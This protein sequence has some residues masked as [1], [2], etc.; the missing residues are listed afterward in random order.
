MTSKIRCIL[1]TRES[2]RR[3]AWCGRAIEAREHSY[4]S[5]DHT[6]SLMGLRPKVGLKPCRQCVDA[7][8]AALVEYAGVQP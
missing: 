8:G 6:L 2:A 5:V 1:R 7:V 3:I 4:A